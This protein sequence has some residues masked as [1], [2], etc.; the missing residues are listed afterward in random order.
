MK[1]AALS[2]LFLLLATTASAY[3]IKH[4][5]PA[6]DGT[7]YYGTCD[8]GTDFVL[9]EHANQ[10]FVYEGPLGTGETSGEEGLDRAARAACGE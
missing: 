5:Y 2:A 3:Q 10:R 4:G 7:E 6:P 1:H 8:D 9:Y